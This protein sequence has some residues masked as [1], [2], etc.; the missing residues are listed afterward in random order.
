MACHLNFVVFVVAMKVL[1]QKCIWD[2][3]CNA[4]GVSC[5]RVMPE[6]PLVNDVGGRV[7]YLHVI[8]SGRVQV[9]NPQAQC[10][11]TKLET[12]KHRAI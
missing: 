1:V 12:G 4:R 9:C 7:P 11:V 3:S 8:F 2:V 6:P 5:G 10:C